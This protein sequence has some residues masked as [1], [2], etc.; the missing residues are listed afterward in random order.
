MKLKIKATTPCVKY[1]NAT[2][3]EQLEKNAGRGA[4]G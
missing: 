2:P 3:D 1:I 4:G